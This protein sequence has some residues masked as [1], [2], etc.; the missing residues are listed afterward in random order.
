MSKV[1]VITK[2]TDAC[3]LR[4][5]Y[6]YNSGSDYR[7]TRLRLDRFEKLLQLLVQKYD[8]VNIVWHGG[9][10]LSV[11]LDYFRQAMDIEQRIRYQTGI[12][13]ENCVQTNGTLIDA[14][15]I[16][17][18]KEHEFHVGVSFDG[19]DNDRFRQQGSKTLQAMKAMK[20]AG[21]KF[22]CNAVVA[23]NDYDLKAN[24]R[25]FAEL[26]A[27][28]DYSMVISEGG[29]TSL[30]SLAAV[31]YADK[32]NELFDEWL[33]DTDG[34]AIRT[35]SQY[36]SMAVGGCF[37][38]CTTCSCHTKYLGIDA[39]GMIFNCGRDGIGKYPFGHVE[40]TDDIEALFRSEGARAL[41]AG[42]VARREKC[43]AECEYFRLCAGGCADI[44]I[45]ENGL[46]NRPTNYCHVFRTVYSH[47]EQVMRGLLEQQTPLDTLNPTVRKVLARK[48]AGPD[49]KNEVDLPYQGN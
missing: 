1:Q 37:R 40:Q 3:N 33:Y 38:I 27:D 35:F 43:R 7:G 22:G 28:F 26:G 49:S 13:I 47:V 2:V 19:I 6:C 29:A 9:E 41:I 42:S 30:P 18:F 20:A 12:V 25:F 34:V 17:F 21:L 11:G 44:A 23:D 45:A 16:R 15:W 31:S 24:Y 48:F 39:D 5:K 8:T 32:L 14:E 10:P 4:C 46:E 36:I